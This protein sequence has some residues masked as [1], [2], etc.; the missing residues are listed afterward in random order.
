MGGGGSTAASSGR[1][2]QALHVVKKD[3]RALQT[4]GSYLRRPRRE[5]RR[6]ERAL[7]VWTSEARHEARMLRAA[8]RGF[9]RADHCFTVF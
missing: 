8:A 4:I 5:V 6:L 3:G 7:W 2:E 1:R 9:S